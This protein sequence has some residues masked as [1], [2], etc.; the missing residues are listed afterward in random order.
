MSYLLAFDLLC[1]SE[2]VC[3]LSFLSVHQ[4]RF[5]GLYKYVDVM[6]LDKNKYLSD[7][8]DINVQA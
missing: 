4:T 7:I 8:A 3:D 5:V 1:L 6:V 2:M